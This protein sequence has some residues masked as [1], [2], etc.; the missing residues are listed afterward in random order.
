MSLNPPLKSST[1]RISNP[2]PLDLH[3]LPLLLLCRRPV[4][5]I[6][7][8]L[9]HPIHPPSRPRQPRQPRRVGLLL[10]LSA[11]LSAG[12]VPLAGTL[13]S[14]TTAGL[15]RRWLRRRHTAHHVLNLV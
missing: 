11:V 3:L 7:N 14:T 1:V 15:L 10:R 9:K 12:L 13:C 2:A 8:P 5:H 4:L 6:V